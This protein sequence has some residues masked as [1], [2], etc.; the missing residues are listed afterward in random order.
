MICEPVRLLLDGPHAVSTAGSPHML[1]RRR[2]AVLA[3]ACM[4]LHGRHVAGDA[5]GLDLASICHDACEL[6]NDMF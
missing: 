1:A 2:E 3:S 6:T 4:V 5:W